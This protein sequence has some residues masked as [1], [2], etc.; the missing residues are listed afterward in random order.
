MTK[1]MPEGTP[2]YILV[3]IET[4]LAIAESNIGMFRYKFVREDDLNDWYY[5]NELPE[6]GPHLVGDRFGFSPTTIYVL[7]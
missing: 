4:D 1:L 7:A 5:C 2:V 6:P 3:A